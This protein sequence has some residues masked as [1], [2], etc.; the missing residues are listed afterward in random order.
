VL[1]LPDN[2]TPESALIRDGQPVGAPD[3]AMPAD[4]SVRVLHG[5]YWQAKQLFQQLTAGGRLVQRSVNGPVTTLRYRLRDG[6][7][8][9]YVQFT[10][11]QG[12]MSSAFAEILVNDASVPISRLRFMVP[13]GMPACRG[14]ALVACDGGGEM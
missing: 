9:T 7:E 4:A 12:S 10:V 14:P 6:A 5:Y 1:P 11:T 13:G 2:P 3:P 8:L